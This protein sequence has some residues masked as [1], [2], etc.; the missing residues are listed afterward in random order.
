MN[1]CCYIASCEGKHRLK[2]GGQEVDVHSLPFPSRHQPTFLSHDA[3]CKAIRNGCRFGLL[4]QDRF[5][6][7][8]AQMPIVALLGVYHNIEGGD[9]KS[10]PK[11]VISVTFEADIHCF[12]C[13]GGTTLWNTHCFFWWSQNMNS[14]ETKAELDALLPL[15][16]G[17]SPN[18]QFVPLP[19]A[20][21]LSRLTR[22][23]FE[24]FRLLR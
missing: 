10:S 23:L 12:T 18:T 9:S 4:C 14:M 19:V 3:G 7:L 13:I 5:G 21:V 17:N 22:G 1:C 11:L 2:V 8:S 6:L 15:L 20:F 16:K 24:S